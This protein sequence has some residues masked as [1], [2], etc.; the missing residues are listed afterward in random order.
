[1]ESPDRNQG[2]VSNLVKILRRIT[3]T[4]QIAPFV[5]LLLI[6]VCLLT[7]SVLPDW[8]LRVFDNLLNVPVYAPIGFLF[9]GRML[10]LC[11]WFRTACLLP[12][13]TRIEGYVDSFVYTFTQ[14]E[15]VIVNAVTAVVFLAFVFFT[16]RHFRHGRA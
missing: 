9:L 2:A 5:Y 12:F 15:V 10:K 4:V 3:R 11:S 14:N 8:A 1:M 13:T 7:E 6:L 16:F